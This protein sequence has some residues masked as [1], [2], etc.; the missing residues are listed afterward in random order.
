MKIVQM[1]ISNVANKDWVIN[2]VL[3]NLKRKEYK[4]KFRR[5]AICLYCFQLH[6]WIKPEDF[7]VD[8]YYYF[9]NILNPD[10][11]RILCAISFSGGL[12][13]FL[14]DSCDIYT[15]NISQEMMQKLKLNE[16]RIGTND[17]A[18][19]GNEEAGEIN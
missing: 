2:K 18:D 9:E 6:E 15:D 4:L 3:T 12:K 14:I 17:A 13:G 19:A 5:E 1:A 16:I 7:T 8:E 10:A 11:E